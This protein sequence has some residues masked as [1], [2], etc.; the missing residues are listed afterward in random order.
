MNKIILCIVLL[1]FFSCGK[2]TKESEESQNN[3]GIKEVKREVDV[4]LPIQ[5][6]ASIPMDTTIGR[7]L[8]KKEMATIFTEPRQIELGI[9]NKIYQV[10]SYK[11]TANEY[12][13]V[14]TDHIGETTPEKDTL[15]DN[16]YALNLINKN[17]RL[18]KKSTVK[19]EIKDEWETSIGFWNQYCQLTDLNNDGI[20]DPILVY[21]TTGQ[22]QY[23]DG[24]VRIMTYYNRRRVSI[25]HQNSEIEDGRM[26]KINKNL[27]TFPEEIQEAVKET[28]RQM[29]KNGHATFTKG[30]EKEMKKK[31]TRLHKK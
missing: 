14:L 28:M 29:I 22:N 9:S 15:Y 31:A 12:F 3:S 27:Y 18:K 23:E 25:K 10:Y 6:Y 30:W 4:V 24:R 20:I 11:D 19:G 16:V 2:L 1:S 7:K 8:S 17:Y 26:T 21:G 5:K 13:L